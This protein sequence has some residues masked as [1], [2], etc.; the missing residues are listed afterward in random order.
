MARPGTTPPRGPDR[1]PPRTPG[2]GSERLEGR[3]VVLEALRAGRTFRF[4]LLDERAKASDKVEEISRLAWERAIPLQRVPRERLDALSVTGGHNGVIAETEPLA[5]VPLADVLARV[6][7]R[8]TP[9]FLLAL[10]G[11]PTEEDFGAVLRTCDAVAVDAV[12]LPP[13][14]GPLLS[15]GARRVSMGA[16]ERLPLVQAPLPAMLERCRA[17]GL[18]VV[19]VRRDGAPPH[20]S[21]PLSGPLVMVIAR[22]GSA[23]PSAEVAA[24]CDASVAVVGIAPGRGLPLS[25][26]AAVLLYERERQERARVLAAGR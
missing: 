15:A 17:A 3:N 2:R 19:G 14:D 26:E 18:R 1:G 22:E 23:G 8:G 12:L 16:A 25:Q 13:S 10:D 21:V 5:A 4:I 6:A 20:T 11:V 24:F 7:R 9:A